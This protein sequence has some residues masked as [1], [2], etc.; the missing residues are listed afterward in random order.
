MGKEDVILDIVKIIFSGSKEHKKILNALLE[1]E[2]F[3][4][5]L[6][7]VERKALPS[8]RLLFTITTIVSIS[9]II[10]FKII[11]FDALVFFSLSLLMFL[12][13]VMFGFCRALLNNEKFLYLHIVY[14]FI[15]FFLFTFL[16]YTSLRP[17]IFIVSLIFVIAS[18]FITVLN[19]REIVKNLI[20]QKLKECI[21]FSPVIEIHTTLSHL[22]KIQGK[23]LNIFNKD[24][25]VLMD[26]KTK[27]TIVLPWNK[28]EALRCA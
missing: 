19:G 13:S 11:S 16:F 28:I 6:E 24:F 9:A 4:D 17:Q 27:Q 26:V 2:K 22:P 23:V 5:F 21:S 8:T 14:V 20:K 25:I 7:S 12:I 1:C 15:L 10:L 18:L 3:R